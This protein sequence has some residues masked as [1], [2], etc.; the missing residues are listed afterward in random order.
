[1]TQFLAGILKPSVTSH[2]SW[3]RDERRGWMSCTF[4]MLL[5]ALR[6]LVLLGLE[7]SEL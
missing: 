6:K 4:Q 2:Y 5:Q 1:M 3:W 7:I